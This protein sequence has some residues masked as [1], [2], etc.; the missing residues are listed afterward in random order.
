[1]ASSALRAGAKSIQKRM[2]SLG[3]VGFDFAVIL[4]LLPVFIQLFQSCKKPVPPAPV[5]NP[6]PSEKK[7][8]ELHYTATQGWIEGKG[9]YKGPLVNNAKRRIMKEGH[10]KDEAEALAIA[11]LDEAR[12][13]DLDTLAKAVEE[14]G[15]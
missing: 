10:S 6:T 9:K 5:S 4:Q 2:E 11:S 8:W 3:V 14:S 7:A 1:M 15:A 12:L 13:S